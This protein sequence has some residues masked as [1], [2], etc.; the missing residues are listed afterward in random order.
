[1]ADRIT[2]E[3]LRSKF[4]AVVAEMRATL[5]NT[6]CS[7]TVSEANQ[8]CSGLF[9]EAGLLVTL[10]NPLHLSSMADTAAAVLDYFQYDLGSEDILLTNDPYGGG[11]RIQEFTAF[12]PVSFAEEIVLYVGVRAHTEDIGGDLRGNFNPRA[13]DIW[14]EGVRCPPV[15]IYRDGKLLKDTLNTIALN[16]RNPNAFRL[17]L[18][19]M[20]SAIRV[21]Q[22]RM[23]ELLHDY[24]AK[25]VLDALDWSVDYAEN[26]FSSMLKSWGDVS[27]AGRCTLRHDCQQREDLNIHVRLEITDGRLLMDFSSTDAQSTGFVNTT[28]AHALSY[29]LLPVFASLDTDIPK[30][31]GSLRCVDLVAPKGSLVNADLP[32]PTGWSASHVGAELA[33]AV[34]D[35][36]A[37]I[38]PDTCADVAGNPMLIFM[39]RRGIRNGFTVEQLE[40][41]NYARFTQGG[42]SGAAGRDGWGMPGMSAATP[43]PSIELFEAEADGK[44]RKLEYVTDSAGA[45]QWRGGPGTEASIE[46]PAPDPDEFYLTACVIPRQQASGFAGGAAGTDNAVL[47]RSGDEETNVE[48]AYVDRPLGQGTELSI[49]MGG[50][51]GWGNPMSRKPEQVLSDVLDGYVSPAAAAA[52]YGVVVDPEKLQI[53]TARTA[54]LR[55]DHIAGDSQQ[56]EYHHD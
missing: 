52:Q 4:D 18:E 3:V 53:D 21:G 2:A 35:A 12:A 38:L 24:G 29:A 1:M 25:V 50:G 51:A 7:T 30:N 44:I 34:T 13:T 33:L 54:E 15:K 31:A 22:A 46:L 45:G 41:T 36:L 48:R 27:A 10:D 39:I 20:F 8:C 56:E 42:C 40:L 37:G 55:K 26:R 43:L 16:S 47:V 9:T 17:D 49:R 11:S 6:A 5:I 28:P 23:G 14:A 19:A 32:A